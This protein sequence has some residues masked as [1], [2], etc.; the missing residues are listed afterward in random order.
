M[1]NGGTATFIAMTHVSSS[2][3]RNDRVAAAGSP[4]DASKSA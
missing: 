4:V 3:H 1:S 2:V